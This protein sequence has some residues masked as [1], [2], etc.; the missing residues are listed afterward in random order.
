M[1]TG[2]RIGIVTPVRDAGPWLDAMLRSVRGQTV[3]DWQ[4]IVVDDRSSDGSRTIA[5]RHA[6]DDARISVVD[7]DGD[8]AP[9]ARALGRRLLTGAPRYLYFP[10]ADDLLDPTLLERLAA[11]LDTTPAAVAAYC[12]YRK[13]AEDGTPLGQPWPPRIVQTAL[14][15]RRLRDDEPDTPFHSIYA[16]AAPV[17]EAVT[18]LRTGDYDAAGGWELCPGQGGEGVDLFA[19]LA[20]RGAVQLVPE[21]LYAYRAHDRQHTRSGVHDERR[22]QL[23]ATW[24]QRGA[25]WPEHA[26]T[27]AAGEW[28]LEHRYLPWIGVRS[29]ARLARAG[30]LCESV[31]F[32]AGALRRYRP[33]RPPNA[34]ARSRQ[35][36]RRSR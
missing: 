20:L 15:V 17:V 32:L 16:W 31:R 30:R 12:K 29:A 3:E 33:V 22:R 24:R 23:R 35:G 13:V 18:M 7:G 28:F 9:A 2:A 36:T 25:D 34:A 11:R 14:W 21:A 1:A 19:R 5:E 10:D 27:I 6:A 8:G 26:T 4:L